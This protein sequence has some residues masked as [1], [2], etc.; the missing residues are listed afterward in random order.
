MIRL[1]TFQSESS[2]FS[3]RI[4]LNGQQIRLRITYNTRAGHFFAMLTDTDGE[5]IGRTKLVL[6]WPIFRNHR[7]SIAFDGDFMV[8]VDDNT[9]GSTIDYDTFGA[10]HTLYYLTPDEVKEWEEENGIR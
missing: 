2:D 10:G 6:N 5:I 1:P 8:K 7:A 4:N 9:L 3:Y